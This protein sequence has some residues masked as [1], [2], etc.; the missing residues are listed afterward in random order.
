MG[1]KCAKCS[2]NANIA[3]KGGG[4]ETKLILSQH[5][6]S[7]FLHFWM[8]KHLEHLPRARSVRLSVHPS[9]TLQILWWPTWRTEV[10]IVADMEVDILAD[11]EVDK[12]ADMVDKINIDINIGICRHGNPIW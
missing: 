6:N 2:Q 1:C 9:V 12:V 8:C 7:F 10:D 4:L 3:R 5:P 11:I